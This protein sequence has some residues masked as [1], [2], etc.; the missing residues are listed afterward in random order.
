M[1][2]AL[3]IL[4]VLVVLALFAGVIVLQFFLSRR[5]SKV[6]GLILPGISFALSLMTSLGMALYMIMPPGGASAV[7]LAMVPV[8]VL[9]NIPTGVLLAI[10]AGCRADLRK[11]RALEKMT[12]QD[13]E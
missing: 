2:T 6:P 7:V 11:H 9:C 10:Y 12:I 3:I 8:F 13:L 4:V 5:D 1:R